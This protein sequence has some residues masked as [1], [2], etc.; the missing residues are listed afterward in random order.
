MHCFEKKR[1]CGS[2][3]HAIWFFSSSMPVSAWS[4]IS[5]FRARSCP[6]LL[7]FLPEINA[8]IGSLWQ[9]HR[10]LQDQL[11]YRYAADFQS[12]L[13]VGADGAEMEPIYDSQGIYGIQQ[14]VM[15]ICCVG[16]IWWEYHW[17]IYIYIIILYYIMLY[18][19]IL[20]YII[21]YYI[22]LYYIILYYIILYIEISYITGISFFLLGHHGRYRPCWISTHFFRWEL[23][24]FFSKHQ[25][26]IDL[27]SGEL[28]SWII[29]IPLRSPYH[30]GHCWGWIPMDQKLSTMPSA[31]SVLHVCWR[32]FIFGRHS[33][34][35]KRP[36]AKLRPFHAPCAKP[37]SPNQAD[38]L[39]NWE[40]HRY[41]RSSSGCIRPLAILK[42]GMRCAELGAGF[43]QKRGFR[44]KFF[45]GRVV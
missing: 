9:Q 41:P 5:S 13:K 35:Q 44:V 25:A 34:T 19:I 39:R 24:D 15:N 31:G 22:I 29:R 26:V 33:S 40:G 42:R 43:F 17:D 6:R 27:W 18:Y 21:L 37:W 45:L 1:R 16:D 8:E 11:L 28:I 2:T 32:T 14:Y 4:L 23:V 7:N 12:T 10:L 30:W 3:S 36:P 38:Q 20:Y